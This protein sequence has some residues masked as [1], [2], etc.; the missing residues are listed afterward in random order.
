MHLLRI[1]QVVDDYPAALRFYGALLDGWCFN[2]SPDREA[3]H[4]WN[5]EA[6]AEIELVSTQAAAEALGEYLAVPGTTLCCVTQDV[7]A[8]FARV[9]EA[10]AEVVDELQADGDGGGY[11]RLRA[12]EGSIVEL[13]KPAAVSFGGP[14]DE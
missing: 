8:T 9:R 14:I 12:P 5:G 3:C 11:G 10:G 2:H 13:R 6:G 4:I 1:R 7:D